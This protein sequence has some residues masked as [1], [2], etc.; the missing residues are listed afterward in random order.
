MNWDPYGVLGVPRTAT[1]Q[2]IKKAFHSQARSCHPDLHPNDAAAEA[3]FKDLAAAWSILG[4]HEARVRFD[5]QPQHPFGFTMPNERTLS[6][7][8]E[9]VRSAVE[10]VD[11][12]F[13][14]AVLPRYLEAYER[15]CGAELVY[16]LLHDVDELSVLDFRRQTT[17]SIGARQ[18]AHSLRATLRLR[19][20]SRMRQGAQG[21]IFVQLT[22]VTERDLTWAAMTVYA[23]S[24]L[25]DSCTEADDIA[26]K[27]LPEVGRE[28]VRYLEHHLPPSERPIAWRERK[29]DTSLPITMSRAR[30]RDN[31]IVAV[32]MTRV[33]V[34]VLGLVI[35]AAALLWACE[36]M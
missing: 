10:R 28:V 34:G 30:R 19:L 7:F 9:A 18:R 8:A 29:G 14:E 3:R 11:Q 26:L 1:R 36:G 17:P 12:V 35:A 4:D 32:Q 23:G 24:L 16:R 20:D 15:G 22:R 13:F 31:F 6:K 5:T 33:L 2:E 25:A 21:L 27:L